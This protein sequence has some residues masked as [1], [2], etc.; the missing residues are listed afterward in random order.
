MLQAISINPF[1][2]AG[3]KTRTTILIMIIWS[4]LLTMTISGVTNMV[5][6]PEH[7]LRYA[8]ILLLLWPVSIFILIYA[9]NGSQ[10]KSAMLYVSFLL[11]MIF[12]FSW[13]G[14]GIRGHSI[15]FL[16]IVVLFSGLL[17]GRKEIWVF[18]II[19]TLGTLGLMIADYN[20]LVFVKEPLGQSPIIYWIHIT[21]AIFLLCF[22]EN[23]SVEQLRKSLNRSQKLLKLR[24]ASEARLKLRNER[25]SEIAFLQSH[26]VRQPLSNI[27]GLIYLI[28]MN[29]LANPSNAELI[30]HLEASAKKLDDIIHEIVKNTDQVDARLN[31]EIEI[32]EELS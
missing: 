20:N 2:V 30:S 28:R 12:G 27:L 22:L 18:G 26:V 1:P 15:K 8:L 32:E 19:A 13:T 17:L 25:L 14:G 23:L 9:K 10:Y 3:L 29:G 5:L 11:L 6:Q 24:E 21:S 4:V 31:N 16:P 7:L